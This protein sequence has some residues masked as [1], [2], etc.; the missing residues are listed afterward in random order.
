MLR[1]N[2]S[3][4]AL[5]AAQAKPKLVIESGPSDRVTSGSTGSV[6]FGGRVR[7]RMTIAEQMKPAPSKPLTPEEIEQKRWA[8]AYE[9]DYYRRQREEKEAKEREER[10]HAERRAGEE[11]ARQQAEA[12]RKAREEQGAAVTATI[13]ANDTK[14]QIRE[15]LRP[16]PPEVVLEVVRGV[17]HLGLV[18]FF[19]AYQTVLREVKAERSEP[20]RKRVLGDIRKR[21]QETAQLLKEL[22]KESM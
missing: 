3:L 15:L 5:Y 14:G 16:E 10:R 20:H 6:V 19:P 1:R 4:S 9:D 18:G 7:D 8:K 22:Q 2:E 13:L 12:D 21:L 17:Q 11:K